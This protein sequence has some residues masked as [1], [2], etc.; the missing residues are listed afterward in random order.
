MVQL[1]RY[2][3]NC[4]LV[5]DRRAPW[6]EVFRYFT[7]LAQ[8]DAAIAEFHGKLAET[9]LHFREW[10]APKCTRTRL[11]T[12]EDITE[13]TNDPFVIFKEKKDVQQTARVPEAA[14]QLL[15]VSDYVYVWERGKYFKKAISM[16][17][18]IDKRR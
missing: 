7:S 12:L 9:D 5:P 18:L 14:T 1:Y 8:S 15:A 17:K 3:M 2:E 16:R 13:I 11:P 10:I 6:D 4:Y